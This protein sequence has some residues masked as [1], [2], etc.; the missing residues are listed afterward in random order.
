MHDSDPQVKFESISMSFDYDKKKR[1][2][3]NAMLIIMSCIMLLQVSY[4]F[5]YEVRD[6]KTTNYQNRVELMENGVLQG[7][8]SLLAPDGVVRTFIYS[9]DGSG[10]QVRLL[11]II[12]M[13]YIYI[14][15]IK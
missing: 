4:Q 11:E 10:Y 6:D 2:K 5:A 8:F 3:E 13:L 12:T 9:D 1:K 15:T 7:S 14:Y